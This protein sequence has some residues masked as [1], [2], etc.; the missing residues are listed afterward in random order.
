MPTALALFAAAARAG[1]VRSSLMAGLVMASLLLV[2]QPA[3]ANP[4]YASIVVDVESG[5]VLHA[6]HADARRFPASLT[7]IM[8]LYMAFEALER[9]EVSLDDKLVVSPRA[10]AQPPSKLGLR[11]GSTIKLRMRSSHW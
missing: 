10:A 5:T 11:A 6:R 3:S 4:R 9:G 2:T 7:K 1:A 8:T